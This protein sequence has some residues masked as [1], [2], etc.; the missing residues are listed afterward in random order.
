MLEP[1]TSGREP[2]QPAVGGFSQD[3]RVPIVEILGYGGPAIALVGTGAVVGTFTSGSRVVTLIV[4][5]ILAAALF[6]AGFIVGG[7]THDRL[8]RM[9]SVLWFLSVGAA[10]SF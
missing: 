5:L 8:Q 3:R 4:S 9:R 7:A 2:M 6:V 1:S 10:Q